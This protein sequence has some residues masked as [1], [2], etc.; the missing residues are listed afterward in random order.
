MLT[1]IGFHPTPDDKPTAQV[2]P[3][4]LTTVGINPG[5]H[6]YFGSTGE[7][8]RWL[9]AAQKAIAEAVRDMTPAEDPRVEVPH[10]Q[11]TDLLDAI[12]SDVTSGEAA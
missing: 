3:N 4:G 11:F 2:L 1:N 8:Y 5:A 12:C 9:H 6:V 7:A 10:Q